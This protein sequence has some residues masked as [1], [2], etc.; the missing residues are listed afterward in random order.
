MAGGKKGSPG[1]SY[2][3]SGAQSRYIARRDAAVS[4]QDGSGPSAGSSGGLF[5]LSTT[6]LLVIG[7]AAV[8]FFFLRKKR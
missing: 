5:G 1:P 6:M 8:Y 2:T 7:G 3:D 4:S